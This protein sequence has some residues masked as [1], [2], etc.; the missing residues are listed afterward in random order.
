M[1]NLINHYIFRKVS[2]FQW[3]KKI[4]RNELSAIDFTTYAASREAKLTP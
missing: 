1:N 4:N 2:P 3:G